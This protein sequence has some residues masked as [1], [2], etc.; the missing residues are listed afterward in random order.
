M[1]ETDGR[2]DTG[3]GIEDEDDKDDLGEKVAT[4][5][6]KT[7]LEKLKKQYFQWRV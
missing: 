1:G 3:L 2:E 6:Q 4:G 7:L 5:E